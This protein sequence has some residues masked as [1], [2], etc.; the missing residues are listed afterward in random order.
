MRWSNNTLFA[1]IRD[2]QG[3]IRTDGAIPYQWEIVAVIRSK[4]RT[5]VTAMNQGIHKE[6]LA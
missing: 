1:P 2:A 4:P 3:S 6:V 5:I